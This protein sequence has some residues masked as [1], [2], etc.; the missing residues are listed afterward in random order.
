MPGLGLVVHLGARACTR[1][2]DE[3][4]AGLGPDSLSRRVAEA[5]A[6]RLPGGEPRRAD[7]AESMALTERTL[8]RQLEGEQTSFNQLL[9]DTRRRLA[10]QYLADRRYPLAQ[11]ALLIGFRDESN[12]TRACRRWFGQP[13]GLAR[14]TALQERRQPP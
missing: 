14:N 13:P 11:V 4:L 9:D 7:V 3:R 1:A 10:E 12:F 5:I 6:N 8:Q 2:L